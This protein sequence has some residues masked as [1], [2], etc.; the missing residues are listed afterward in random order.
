MDNL[1]TTSKEKAFLVHNRILANGQIIGNALL[2]ICRDLKTMRDDNL[3]TELGYET[4]E[5]YSE[6]ACGIKQRQ[7]YSYI[8]AYEKLGEKFIE[9]KSDWGITKLEL[10]SQISSYERDEFLEENKV[11]ELSVRE[12]KKQVDDFKNQIE[13]LSFNLK[14]TEN[15]NKELTQQLKDMQDSMSDATMTDVVATVEPDSEV[16]QAA[17][18]K[19]VKQEQ[20]ANAETIEKLKAQLKDEKAKVKEVTE[21]KDKEIKAAKKDALEKANQK[22]DKLLAEKQQSDEKLQQALKSAKAANADEDITAIRFLFTNLQSTANEIKGHLDK[23][24]SKDAEQAKK[25]SAV[26][27]NTLNSIAESL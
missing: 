10:I 5:D 16:I 15:E 26:M 2:E 19:A 8:S 25:L 22:I 1:T 18:D 24:A 17:V 12:L 9:E 27:K 14:S 6:K 20:E 4:F 7:A 3:F 23:V 11:E 13:Q 21:S